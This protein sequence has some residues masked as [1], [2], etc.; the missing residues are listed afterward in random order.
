MPTQPSVIDSTAKRRGWRTSTQ[1]PSHSL[2]AEQAPHFSLQM[3][4][5]ASRNLEQQ[6]DKEKQFNFSLT[7]CSFPNVT[8]FLTKWL[9]F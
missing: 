5:N 3:T 7:G 9:I 4:G 6:A 8:A 2:T 1:P